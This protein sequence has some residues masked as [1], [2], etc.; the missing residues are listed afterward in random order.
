MRKLDQSTNYLLIFRFLCTSRYGHSDVHHS[1]I[2][3]SLNIPPCSER[4]GRT[5]SQ[6]EQCIVDVPQ[7]PRPSYIYS[8]T[9]I[10][11]RLIFFQTTATH[12]E[13]WHFGGTLQMRPGDRRPVITSPRQRGTLV[14]IDVQWIYVNMAVLNRHGSIW[15]SS[16]GPG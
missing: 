15:H 16:A 7:L 14:H 6:Q 2:H 8:W 3:A 11:G 9:R 12:S 5:S 13:P 10:P 4:H 1:I